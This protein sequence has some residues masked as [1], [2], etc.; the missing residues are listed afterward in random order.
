MSKAV[1]S[2]GGSIA[3]EAKFADRIY[4]MN[5]ITKAR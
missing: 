1:R 2:M 4:K 5:K 3:E